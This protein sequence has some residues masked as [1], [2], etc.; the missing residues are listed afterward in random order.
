MWGESPLQRL[1]LAP[2]YLALRGAD[3]IARTPLPH[4]SPPSGAWRPGLSVVVP[5]RD[6][7][8]MLAEALA[9]LHAALHEID[10]PH[11]VVVVVN[12]AHFDRYAHLRT[13]F[14]SVDFVHSV[15]PL[16]FSTAVARGLARA[17][18]DWT[19]LMNNDMTLD[20]AAL[21]ELASHRA[22]DRFA[23]CA[24]IFQRSSD[25]RREETG[26][27]DWY[28]DASGVH[29]YHATVPADRGVHPHL[30]GSGGATL[31]RTAPLARY[32]RDSRC[33]DPFYWEDIEW[34]LRARQDGY[35]VM[36]CPAA[37][38][39]HRH[40][41]TTARF[42]DAAEIDRIVARNALLFDARNRPSPLRAERLME[43]VCDLPYASQRELARPGIAAGV[44]ISRSRAARRPFAAPALVDPA[45]RW[46]ALAPSSFSY[47]MRDE[48]TAPATRPRLLVVTPFAVF[49]PRHG[50]ARRIAGLLAPLRRDHDV[51]L[52]TDE[53]SLH[54]ARSFAGFDDLRAVYL[55]QREEDAVAASSTTLETRMRSHV[56]PALRE[57]VA[58]ALARH[59]PALVQIEHAEL[60]PLVRLRGEGQRW[61]LDLHDA[62]GPADF[63]SADEAARFQAE[64]LDAYDAVTVCSEEDGALIRHRHVVCIPNGTSIELR[65]YRPSV[66]MQ[67]MFMGPFRYAQNLA[68]IRRFLVDAW[69]AIRR[70]VPDARLVILGGDGAADRVGG[71]PAFA[72]PGIQLLP[73]RENV[74]EL[75][76]A[77]ALT[78]NPLTGIRGSSI[79]VVESLSAGRVCV[80]TEE[81][82]RGF[83][84]AGFAGLVVV[85]DAAAIAAP[86]IRLLRDAAERHRVEAPD[87]ARLARYQWAYCADR[88]RELY[89][90]LRRDAHA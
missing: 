56:H 16:G 45:R 86:V 77:S 48:A 28:A 88:A 37:H 72:Q 30:A 79:K 78:V 55:V 54:D 76:D 20:R 6:A 83:A 74:R 24:Q 52:V 33:Y 75:L 82:A 4:R 23:L 73:H 3:R 34:G 70:A 19:F 29:V 40:R 18:H 35:T 67:L 2:L 14:P 68:G 1:R 81:G 49:P 53:A 44:G 13:G 62:Y 26:F 31:F 46:T 63:S 64:V 39:F 9:S 50:G 65:D 43:R 59:R 22:A 69:P 10:E 12:G 25:G 41:A 27:T 87:V 36:F 85:P 38:A 66:S 60:A 58:E 42:F 89:G 47:R 7:P 11:Q 90:R 5:D 84:D 80:S 57:A 61:I 15:E 51:V 17:R 71:D 32:A 21:R 8:A